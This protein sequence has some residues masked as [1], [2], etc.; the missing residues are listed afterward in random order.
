MYFLI[1]FLVNLIQSYVLSIRNVFDFLVPENVVIESCG[2]KLVEPRYVFVNSKVIP[3]IV[4]IFYLI[5][6]DFHGVFENIF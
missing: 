5:N 6:P 2:L 4:L 3:Q 1:S